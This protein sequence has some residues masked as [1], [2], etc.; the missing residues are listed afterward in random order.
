MSVIKFLR[1]IDIVDL[2]IK[3]KDKGFVIGTTS[4]DKVRNY[5]ILS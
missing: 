2:V 1:R 4:V 3:I 5:D